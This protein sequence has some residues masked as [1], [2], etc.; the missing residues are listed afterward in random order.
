MSEEA[1][2]GDHEQLWESHKFGADE[3]YCQIEKLCNLDALPTPHGFQ[4]LA[5]PIHLERAS[6]A[7]ARVVALV[8]DRRLTSFARWPRI[9]VHD[10]TC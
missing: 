7:W 3:E 5:L 8:Q 4:V 1:R 2:A 9:R 10:A 6:G